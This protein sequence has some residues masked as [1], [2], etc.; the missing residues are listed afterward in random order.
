MSHILVFFMA[1]VMELRMEL[2]FPGSTFARLTPRVVAGVHWRLGAVGVSGVGV[3]AGEVILGDFAV[4]SG[5]LSFVGA[6]ALVVLEAAGDAFPAF[7]PST[8][9]K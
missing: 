5:R 8:G 3:V 2:I 1:E 9:E 7:S 6:P 4:V